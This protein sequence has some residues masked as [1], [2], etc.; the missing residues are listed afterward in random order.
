MNT[1]YLAMIVIALVGFLLV[2]GM[3]TAIPGFSFAASPTPAAITST[4]NAVSSSISY[5]GRLTDADGSPLNGSYTM[6]FIVYDDPVAGS[7]ISDT[8]N[9]SVIVDN[10]LFEVSLGVD[11]A[12]FNGQ[13]L[14]LSII[15]EGETLSPRQEIL[16]APYALSLRPGAQIV[17]DA[18]AASDAA[19]SSFTPATGT[20]LYADA[21]GGAG[22]VGYS[23]DNYGVQ[24]S[25]TSSWGGYFTS[26]DG[27][28][29]RVDTTG[30]DHYDH[31][32]YITSDGGYAVYAQ[33]ASNMAVRGE[34]GDITGIPQP[35]GPIGVV[36]L[37][38]NRGV[39]GSSNSGT[40]V[41]ASS[42]SNY[43]VWGQSTS[44]R[45]VTG[46]TSRS[47][48]NYGFYT[49]DNMYSK[50][51]NLLNSVMMVM[52]NNGDR[53]LAPG[54]VVVFSGIN[55]N[56][57]GVDGPVVQ[58]RSAA[59]ANST[60]VAG[61][62][63]SR[64][65]IDAVNPDLE[66]EDIAAQGTA[67]DV[68]PEGAAAPGEYVLVVVQ[69]PAEV[70][71]DALDASIQ[72][73]DLLATHGAAGMAGKAA[74]ILRDGVETAPPGVVFGKALEAADGTRQKIFVFVTLQ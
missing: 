11:Q 36:G 10:G 54:D 58:V 29:I 53:P 47:D 22:V 74:T 15:I 65:N 35:L 51:V 71:V 17:G 23:A 62:V 41:Y 50:N 37:G 49:P 1:K 68:T 64:F 60:A 19:L 44:Y 28:G 7:A 61:V 55:R 26:V 66:A 46:R 48:D 43:G 42:D 6:R 2:A 30:T 16:P 38:Q 18:I 25:S 32:A 9:M 4:T 14:W 12:D 40:G 21:A 72:P 57:V 13:P 27:Y 70:N 59:Q 56:A 5:Q 73:G 20:A 39:V 52:Q 24:G 3:A 63:F 67:L 34:A 31:G 33:S 69:G 45:G 8:G